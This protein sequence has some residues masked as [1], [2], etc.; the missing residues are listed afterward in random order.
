MRGVFDCHPHH[1][2]LKPGV[3]TCLV[4]ISTANHRLDSSMKLRVK[5]WRVWQEIKTSPHALLSF[6]MAT[7][8]D[9]PKKPANVQLAITSV[10]DNCRLCKD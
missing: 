2:I 9:T 7:K 10:N 5:V 6:S 4:S 8:G 3:T 1:L